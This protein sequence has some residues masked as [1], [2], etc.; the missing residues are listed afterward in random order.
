M[1]QNSLLLY[2]K[3]DLKWTQKEIPPLKKDEVLIKTIAGAI[4][5][6]TELSQYMETDKNED[7][8]QYP[9]GTGY[10]SYREIIE[11][12]SEVKNPKVGD[13]V[14]AFYGHKDYEIIKSQNA[15]PVPKEIH[16]SNALLT[17]LSCDSAKGVLKLNPGKEDK[18]LVTGMGTMGLLTVHF[19]KEYMN[20]SHVDVLEP[21]QQE[22]ILPG[23]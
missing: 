22:G 1:N 21:I 20:V 10:E 14:I 9:I 16:H 18:V 15:I 5:I 6:G 4:S 8:L 17:I 11:V 13:R 3:K 2:G 23:C 19:L 7:S 12:G